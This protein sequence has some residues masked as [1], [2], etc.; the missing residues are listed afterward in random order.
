MDS[1]NLRWELI[2]RRKAKSVNQIIDILLENRGIKTPEM[3]KDFFT[4]PIPYN[5]SFKELSLDEIAVK[6][7]VDRIKTAIKN[8]EGIV[9]YGDYDAD[10]VCASA[11]I[12]ECLYLFTKNVIPYIP[13][14]FEEGYGLK[15]DVI[16][17]LKS[18]DPQLKLIITVD[19]GIVAE[20]AVEKAKKLG[21]DVI[22]CDHHLKGR[23]VPKAYSIIHSTK[24]CGAAL[25]WIL[26]REVSKS[27][28]KNSQLGSNVKDLENSL[29]LVAIGT[30]SDQMSLI[31]PN[32]SF[33]KY[34][35]EKLSNTKRVGLLTLYEVAGLT[36]KIASPKKGLKIGSYEV[37]FIIAPRINAMG[38][39]EHALD[40]LRLLC[41]K[42]VAKAQRLAK[43]L[44][45]TNQERQKI[46]EG[47]VEHARRFLSKESY[48][49]VIVVSH[50]DYHEGVIGLAA[51]RLVEEFH[52]PAIVFAKKDF[53]SKAS[54]R[55]IPGFDIIFSIRKLKKLINE[56]GG[57]PM[58]AGFTIKTE[59]IDIFARK[60]A[61][62]SEPLLTQE[63]LVKRLK[64]DCELDFESLSVELSEKLSEFEPTGVGN[65]TPLFLTPKVSVIDAKVVGSEGKHLSL[66]LRKGNK[67]VRG[68]AFGKGEIFNKLYPEQEIDVAYN[69]ETDYWNTSK[70]LQLKIKDIK[71]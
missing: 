37:N 39:L 12:W 7:A 63:L 4:P 8:S 22:I 13:N 52:R 28:S 11:V 10:G 25:A 6:K 19:N 61:E 30:I 21:I 17:R 49:K 59:K 2:N 34:G 1:K 44:D 20:K 62:I 64:I 47:V 68:V 24:V 41:T 32:R 71:Y 26:A 35:L 57:H 36:Q 50:E 46:L 53:V 31:G 48:S 15:S 65:P 60:F 56:G 70:S 55:S 9:I 43:V 38:R 33:A 27:L 14:R 58:A 29:D 54:A 42:S 69:L 5:I 66:V 67:V 16:V 45:K 18:E 40:S 51:S 23:S 3:K